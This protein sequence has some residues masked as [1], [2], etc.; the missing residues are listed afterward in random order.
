MQIIFQTKT[1]FVFRFDRGEDVL[2]ELQ[3]WAAQERVEAASLSAIGASQKV[4]L[5]YYDLATKEYQ[6]HEITENLEV[7]GVTGNL[8]MFDG[9]PVIHM[10]GTFSRA[11]LSVLA[12]HI[13]QLIVS[14]T[15][16]VVLRVLPGTLR[17]QYDPETGLNLLA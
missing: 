5:A 12:G 13:K 9:V 3:N 2:A 10:H 11:D 1:E 8:A 6:N 17:R 14:A 16:E 7:V 15:C 4:V